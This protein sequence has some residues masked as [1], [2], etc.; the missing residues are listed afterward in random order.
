MDYEFAQH[1]IT[2]FEGPVSEKKFHG[3]GHLVFHNGNQFHGE[4]STGK[5][6]GTGKFAW[7]D[8][9][10][11]DGSMSYNIITGEGTYTWPDGSVYHGSV[12]KGK[13]EG[14]GV[15][16]NF[17]NSVR[18]EGEWHEGQKHGYGVCYFDENRTLFYAGDWVKGKKHGW[19]AMTWQSGNRYEGEWKDNQRC[20]QGTMVW[21]TQPPLQE[22]LGLSCALQTLNETGMARSAA[23]APTEEE[24]QAAAELLGKKARHERY[25]GEWKSNAPDGY[26]VYEWLQIPKD[27][28]LNDFVTQEQLYHAENVYKGMFKEGKKH[29]KG[30]CYY[31]DGSV[32][33]GTWEN[34]LKVGE[35]VLWT[36]DGGAQSIKFELDV[37]ISSVPLLRKDLTA[38][39]G[40][41]KRISPQRNLATAAADPRATLEPGKAI[42]ALPLDLRELVETEREAM[43]SRFMLQRMYAHLRF[44]YKFYAKI[45]T[46]DSLETP[47]HLRQPHP[48]VQ[49]PPTPGGV[50][51]E[52]PVLPSGPESTHSGSKTSG[53]HR[54]PAA[55]K[56]AAA[57]PKPQA[58]P[59][60]VA[61]CLRLSQMWEL[62]RDLRLTSA[63][64][65]IALINRLI[66]P[67]VTA[68]PYNKSDDPVVEVH[69]L[70]QAMMKE[71]ELEMERA[72]ASAAAEMIPSLIVE[73][74][75]EVTSHRKSVVRRGSHSAQRRAS[76][77]EI[78]RRTST[79]PPPVS[80]AATID[81]GDVFQRTHTDA[82]LPHTPPGPPPGA[83]EALATGGR[84]QTPGDSQDGPQKAAKGKKKRKQKQE[85]DKEELGH[86]PEM[87]AL[88][89][90]VAKLM[91]RRVD[92]HNGRLQLLF[93]TFVGALVRVAYYRFQF[94]SGYV[95]QPDAVRTKT[96][97][98]SLKRLFDSHVQ[99]AV[100]AL[101][102]LTSSRA[103]TGLPY[104]VP[105]PP[106]NATFLPEKPKR[107]R[108]MRL[109]ASGNATSAVA[110]R[111][112]PSS[113][114]PDLV[115]S[116]SANSIMARPGNTAGTT[117]ATSLAVNTTIPQSLR[118]GNTIP[119][120]VGPITTVTANQTI[121][122]AL[123]EDTTH[124][125]ASHPAHVQNHT[126]QRRSSHASHTTR[127]ASVASVANASHN[128]GV[129]PA[130]MNVSH[131]LMAEPLGDD[132]FN[133]LGVVLHKPQTQPSSTAAKP[134]PP[135]PPLRHLLKTRA[136]L[137]ALK[138]AAPLF[139]KMFAIYSSGNKEVCTKMRLF[140]KMLMDYGLLSRPRTTKRKSRNSEKPRSPSSQTPVM[141]EVLN[142][143]DLSIPIITMRG[144]TAPASRASPGSGSRPAS[145]ESK[146]NAPRKSS[147][148]PKPSKKGSDRKQ[149]GGEETS[150]IGE[151]R[152]S[153]RSVAD[154]EQG[155]TG[156]RR[157]SFRTYLEGKLRKD[158]G[159]AAFSG[160]EASDELADAMASIAQKHAAQAE[161]Q[162]RAVRAALRLP[163]VSK[164]VRRIVEQVFEDDPWHR[165]VTNPLY[166]DR[167]QVVAT[168]RARNAA[169]LATTTV[170][171][172]GAQSEP[173]ASPPAKPPTRG[174]SF[175]ALTQ[176]AHTEQPP[177]APAQPR[178][179]YRDNCII[180]NWD[181]VYA[182]LEMIFPQF[183]EAL[184]IVANLLFPVRSADMKRPTASFLEKLQL[185]INWIKHPPAAPEH[186]RSYS[187]PPMFI[188]PPMPRKKPK[189]RDP[190]ELGKGMS[191]GDMRGRK[192]S[193]STTKRSGTSSASG[194]RKK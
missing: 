74:P 64:M 39:R 169:E 85:E 178:P 149:S 136:V 48:Q 21:I 29:G 78:S 127:R 75:A 22:E 103:V 152:E 58:P 188:P 36:M 80:R 159:D 177:P 104:F 18:Y 10:S 150:R 161:K 49:L 32:L 7:T 130:V 153:Y 23:K 170:S 129:I 107:N 41:E 156:Q 120:D 126:L 83:K 125:S 128:S 99:P 63:D 168:E 155:S 179:S 40:I 1:F 184:C 174:S 101:R 6:N 61:T 135:E 31:A 143:G 124:Q 194:G 192:A 94:T 106:A 14:F 79:V 116:T 66:A 182:D 35:C 146:K 12:V 28:D 37:A 173:V 3:Q 181:Y 160:D 82:D 112:F 96:L 76:S 24:V 68:Q 123:Q 15:Y 175:A 2:K 19:G 131:V 11:Y 77:Q 133:P 20:G 60:E 187:P 73:P 53:T 89:R 26:G 191:R 57:A 100:E 92:P 183:V 44:L 145:A 144:P 46:L 115:S 34:D 25:T 185:L 16:T 172:P 47:A 142:T 72:A 119:L 158:L 157:I 167:E 4:F 51:S 69:A 147:G 140:V 98:S 162:R 114:T 108:S 122:L 93:P 70:Q 171:S 50:T 102:A 138:D 165:I 86:T 164:I 91:T 65:P 38:N 190:E 62:L 5:M 27:G 42:D 52:A 193:P 189:K 54:L 141:A 81:S 43:E 8:G 121:A 139:A 109:R 55:E 33:E 17:D 30:V 9:V 148:S 45:Q 95:Y 118:T 151:R 134:Q 111:L 110:Q 87:Q 88:D 166:S 132:M 113:Q 163:S 13:R 67:I 137:D 56:A 176:V 105:E 71:V 97:V 90:V 117:L 180:Y 154:G 59:P 186:V 84:L